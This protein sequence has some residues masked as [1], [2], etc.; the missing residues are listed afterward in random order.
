MP[1]VILLFLPATVVIKEENI[2]WKGK[3]K[4]LDNSPPLKIVTQPC[5]PQEVVATAELWRQLSY[6]FQ[7]GRIIQFNN[8]YTWP[9]SKAHF[10]KNL[11]RVCLLTVG[12][13]W[14]HYN[15]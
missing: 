12:L 7:R 8:N 6:Y 14:A 11:L 4:Q 3:K 5:L 2:L 15:G 13:V 1:L 9:I 10:I